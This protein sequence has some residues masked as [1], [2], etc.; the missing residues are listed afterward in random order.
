MFPVH[1]SKVQVKDV[2]LCIHDTKLVV[3]YSH[4]IF[5]LRSDWLTLRKAIDLHLCHQLPRLEIQK[6]VD[7]TGE[8]LLSFFSDLSAL[9]VERVSLIYSIS[10]RYCW[11]PETAL[12][13]CV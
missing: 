11:R 8:Y 4:L 10:M 5:E 3:I 1:Y 6:E 13:D 9:I 2:E 7:R 12:I